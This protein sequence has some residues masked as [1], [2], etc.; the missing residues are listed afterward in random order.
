MKKTSMPNSKTLDISSGYSLS[1]PTPVKSPSNSI[2][3]NCQK[4]SS[5]SRRPKNH[6]WYQKKGHISL[7]DLIIYKF[8]KNFTNHRK[9]KNSVVAFSSGPFPNILKYRHPQWDLPIWGNKTLS[10]TY[11]RVQLVWMKVLSDAEE[12]DSGPFNRGGIADL[13][14]L[15]TLLALC[16]KSG[17]TNFW[18][19]DFLF[20]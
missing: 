2:R 12:N 3:Y 17:E 16:Q 6:T 13:P 4:I 5:W 15:R 18:K 8:S 1:S 9:K 10:D 14:L 11:W 19:V 7:S 20:H